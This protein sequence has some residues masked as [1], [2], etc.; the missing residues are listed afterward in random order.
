MGKFLMLKYAVPGSTLNIGI[1]IYL[2][3]SNVSLFQFSWLVGW[4]T[5]W[6]FPK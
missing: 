2:W 3:K 1:A 4:F 6:I 5:N